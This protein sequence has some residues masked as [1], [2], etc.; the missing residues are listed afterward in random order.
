MVSDHAVMFG[1]HKRC[2]TREEAIL[3]AEEL[4]FIFWFKSTI[5]TF[6]KAHDM[7]CYHTQNFRLAK[8]FS[9]KF[10]SVCPIKLV[11][12]WSNALYISI[13]ETCVKSFPQFV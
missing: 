5:T 11:W 8:H 10:F 12:Y 13:Y 6:S 9:H 4:D 3:A 1:C 7:L 2:G